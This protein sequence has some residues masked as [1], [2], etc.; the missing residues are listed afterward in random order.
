[1]HLSCHKQVNIF[2]CV[3]VFI[4]SI[5]HTCKPTFNDKHISYKHMILERKKCCKKMPNKKMPKSLYDVLAL[6]LLKLLEASGGPA[7]LFASL[8]WWLTFV[9]G[10]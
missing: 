1:M 8:R 6:A 2:T 9:F 4:N 10:F 3:N 7:R 5:T